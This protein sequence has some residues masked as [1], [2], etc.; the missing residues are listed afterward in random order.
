ML[1]QKRASFIASISWKHTCRKGIYSY[2]GFKRD[3]L[4]NM[5]LSLPLRNRQ[6]L[7]SYLIFQAIQDEMASFLGL[8]PRPI[9][10]EVAEWDL[11]FKNK[12][13]QRDGFV[14]EKHRFEY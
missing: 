1:S 6:K 11:K 4:H 13:I 9:G 3:I 10:D 2:E 12:M 8:F 5:S 7:Y 14:E